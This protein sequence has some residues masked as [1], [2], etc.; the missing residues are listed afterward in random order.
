[1]DFR[2]HSKLAGAHAFLSPSKY[3][4]VNYDL[5]KLEARYRSALA[6]QRGTKLHSIAHDL[7]TYGINLPDDGKTMSLYVN[8][9]IGYKMTS[10]QVVYYSPLAFGTAD[11][12]SFRKNKLRIH[13]LKTGTTATSVT[14]LVILAAFFCLEYN[15]KPFDIETELRIYQNDD[16]VAWDGD[17]DEITHTMDKVQVFER[18]LMEREAL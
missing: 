10:E 15:I 1:M 4:W 2:D 12:I 13:D 8:D 6:A 7:I 11:T 9:A 14:Q 5:D 3:H 17:P 16:F 18:Y